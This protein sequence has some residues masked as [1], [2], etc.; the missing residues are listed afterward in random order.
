MTRKSLDAFLQAAEARRK[1]AG[2]QTA[3]ERILS[4]PHQDF[5][6]HGEDLVGKW[7][8]RFQR[9]PQ[10][11][12]PL[13]PIQAIALEAC[14]W[15]AQQT[16]PVGMVGNIGVGKGKTL[17]SLLI[18]EV[19]DAKNPLIIVPPSMRDQLEDDIFM[20]SQHYKFRVTL[21]NVLFYSDLSR[22][23]ATGR[24]REIA[25]DLIICDE[26]HNFRHSSAARTKRF[27]RYIQ[28]APETRVVLMSGTLTGSTLSDYAHLC[29]IGLREF[30]PLPTHDHDIDVWGSV[31]NVGGEPDPEAWRVLA[32]LDPRAAKRRDVDAMR[33]AFYR[34]FATAPGVVSTTTSSCD[35]DLE[36]YAQYPDLSEEVRH[37]MRD[38]EQ[39]WAL[40]DG[41]D[42]IDATHY[43]RAM[44]QLSLGFY[45]VWDWPEGEAD[46][47]W[48]EARRGWASGVRSYLSTYARE[49]CDSPFLVEEYV[50]ATGKPSELRHLLDV[51]DGQ[52]HKPEP[53]TMA[54]WLDPSPVLHAVQWAAKQERAFL[55]YHSRAVGDMLEAFGVPV[56]RDGT[57]T[58]DPHKHPVAALS[59][60][61]F[62]KGRNF[63]AWDNQLI[64]EVPTNGATWQQMLGRTHRQGQTS[65]VV[66][67]S[68]FQHTWTLRQKLDKA[69]ERARYAQGMT[70]EPQKLL[71]AKRHF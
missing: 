50:R 32:G 23:E 6:P 21:D 29:E 9:G 71:Q 17:M 61:V 41:T 52:R 24:L 16:S 60:S 48:L 62:N 69:I 27:I 28:Q 54:I 15:S 53:P 26:A 42:I 1:A 67:A 68:I 5:A 59:I 35:A 57:Q 33:A 51:W 45:Y 22:P 11:A 39:T 10:C 12:L 37:L 8:S 4:L 47:E 65:P 46:E 18:P 36:L 13:R 43:H 64:L 58:P 55:W 34:R 63:Q 25:P 2:I 30:S 38:L 3:T 66:S 7:T 31:L 20:W 14:A 49:G 40:P 70:G 19:F 44:G 56:F